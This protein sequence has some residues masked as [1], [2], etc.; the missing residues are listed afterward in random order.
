MSM[1]SLSSAADGRI[2]EVAEAIQAENAARMEIKS[3]PHEETSAKFRLVKKRHESHNTQRSPYWEVFHVYTAETPSKAKCA[4]CN[5]CGV[6]ISYKSGTGGL[7][8]HLKGNHQDVFRLLLPKEEGNMKKRAAASQN[9]QDAFKKLKGPAFKSSG[10]RKDYQAEAV[11]KWI[12]A[13]LQSMN[14]VES[15]R[16]RQMLQAFSDK[17]VPVFTHHTMLEKL[18]TLEEQI[19]KVASIALEGQWLAITVDHWTSRTKDNYTGMTAHWIDENMK[20]HSLRLGCFLHQGDSEAESLIDDFL[21]KLFVEA[22]FDKVNIIAV[23][24][25]TTGNMNKFGK[26][27]ESLQIHHIYC[28]DHVLQLTAR[29]AYS[30]RTYSHDLDIGDDDEEGNN[31]DILDADGDFVLLEGLEISTMQKAR[32]LVEH[33]SRSHLST[34]NLK[35]QQ[36][37]MDM[38]KDKTALTVLVD[39]VTRWWSTYR[40]ID[41]LLHLKPAFS[42]MQADGKLLESKCLAEDDW[43]ILSQVHAALKPFKTAQKLLEG[44]KYVTVSW[45][46][47]M[48]HGIRRS[49]KDA[50]V[51]PANTNDEKAVK[52][53]SIRLLR[54]FQKRWRREEE[55]VFHREVLRGVL[56]RQVGIHPC[57]LLATALDPRFKKLKVLRQQ[58]REAIWSAL[59]VE[60]ITRAGA[61]EDGADEAGANG[62][63]A[64]AAVEALQQ[65][66]QGEGNEGTGR[67]DLDF[68]VD[69]TRDLDG[70]EAEPA[71]PAL[72]ERCRNE[73]ER[74]QGKPQLPVTVEAQ[75]N[76]ELPEFTD[77]LEWW[78]RRQHE[79]PILF[80]LARMYLCIP[81]TSAPS[82]RI[83]SA[84]ELIIRKLRAST[85]PENAG[86]LVFINGALDWY[87]ETCETLAGG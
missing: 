3:T 69:A 50:A 1:S 58:D 16:F 22:G 31:N 23:V 32:D 4:N 17:E 34:E 72:N 76:D 85:K 78:R 64:G 35:N 9:I 41:R 25:D 86:R 55:P 51:L 53:L 26:L 81:A 42:A 2:V 56:Q 84:A 67:A 73:L 60:M 33:F 59:L 40:M 8:R 6:D 5:Y 74:Y 43:K 71:V 65:Q 12:A 80:K 24:S 62:D 15:P 19:R 13:D 47:A 10:E 37:S 30:D 61:D 49:L 28:S 63:V 66:Q 87:E 48:V 21:V 52:N 14:V 83:F 79:F 68:F 11:A 75:G 45:V 54:D 29:Q 39:V 46:P 27:L 77:P 20:L 82:E 44:E 36:K 38:Y 70:P 18:M 7:K 57:I